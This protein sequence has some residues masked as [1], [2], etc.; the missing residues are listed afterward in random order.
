MGEVPGGAYPFGREA[1][2]LAPDK[3]K[4]CPNCGSESVDVY[5]EERLGDRLYCKTGC[6]DCQTQWTAKY[7]VAWM[8]NEDVRAV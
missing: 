3:G 8:E 5:D 1:V 4:V 7:E 6:D 2:T